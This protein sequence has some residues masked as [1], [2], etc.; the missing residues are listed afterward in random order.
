MTHWKM[1]ARAPRVSS[2]IRRC[3]CGSASPLPM[4]CMQPAQTRPFLGR[5]DILASAP[6]FPLGRLAA[7]KPII[8]GLPV[9]YWL[10]FW[11][12]N[13]DRVGAALSAAYGIN[14][15]PLYAA[16]EQ[17][18]PLV[19]NCTRPSEEIPLVFGAKQTCLNE[20]LLEHLQRK[21]HHRSAGDRSRALEPCA[22]TSPP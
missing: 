9:L 11:L 14:R 16:R 1:D 2:T 15:G 20:N 18:A 13:Q 12:Q 6:G 22:A 21:T 4:Y 10:K 8:R 3:N 19:A 17:K 5:S 7:K